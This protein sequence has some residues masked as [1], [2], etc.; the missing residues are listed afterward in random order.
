MENL[1]RGGFDVQARE[2]QAPGHATE[3]AQ[4]AAEDGRWRVVFALGGDGTLR[5]AAVG[6]LGS[7]L[8]L[9]ILPGGTANVLALTLG[10]PGNAEEA[11]KLYR[12]LETDAR[13]RDQ[14]EPC[15]PVRDMDVGLCA[16]RPFL[17]MASVGLDVQVLAH[18][19]PA[20]KRRWGRLA[21]GLQSLLEWWRYDYPLCSIKVGEE[22]VQGSLMALCNIPF[23]AGP[24]K[25]APEASFEDGLLNLVVFRSGGRWPTLAFAL[26]LLRKRHT[27]RPDVLSL[28]VDG[29]ELVGSGDIRVQLDGDPVKLSLPVR[30]SVAGHRVRFLVPP[31]RSGRDG[32]HGLHGVHGVHGVKE[33]GSEVASD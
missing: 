30:V 1:A 2:T 11:S 24:F 27:R 5:E 28:A 26:A 20:F 29:A 10:I 13:K 18:L 7:R 15:L 22:E 14:P 16:G 9:G 33:A 25:M 8:P 17:M 3:L 32:L 31:P 4:A 19:R 6:L 23:Y 12:S 21:V